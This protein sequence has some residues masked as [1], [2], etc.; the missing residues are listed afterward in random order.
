[1]FT[2]TR[3]PHVAATQETFTSYVR[4]TMAEAGIDMSHF[5]PYSCHHIFT[6]VAALSSQSRGGQGTSTS[7]GSITDP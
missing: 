4:S 6:S 2:T 1:M 5:T 7:G 3:S